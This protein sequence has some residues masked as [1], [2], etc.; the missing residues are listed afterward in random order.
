VTAEVYEIK[1]VGDVIEGITQLTAYIAI[2]RTFDPL[3]RPWQY[4]FSYT[5]TKN[6]ISLGNGSYAII[7][8]TVNGVIT[9]KVIN[10]P[11]L[12]AT[13]ITAA[14]VAVGEIVQDVGTAV[15]VEAEEF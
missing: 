15:L 4:G 14:T 7:F 12:I 3:H 5:P 11:S 9:Y 2:L 6:P 13:A 10:F 8:P 1:P